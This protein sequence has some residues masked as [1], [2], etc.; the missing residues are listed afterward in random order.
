MNEDDR[1]FAMA[2]EFEEPFIEYT[3]ERHTL[4]DWEYPTHHIIQAYDCL[5]LRLC[6]TAADFAMNVNVDLF[7]YP[8]TGI[9]SSQ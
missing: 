8:I 7:L 9:V 4:E 3:F 2:E 1:E 5:M 6:L